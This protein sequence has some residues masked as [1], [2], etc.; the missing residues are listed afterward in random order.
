MGYSV[1]I[2]C[3]KA[4]RNDHIG[5]IGISISSNVYFFHMLESFIL[6]QSLNHVLDSWRAHLSYCGEEEQHRLLRSVFLFLSSFLSSQL[7]HIDP[8]LMMI[9][10]WISTF[11]FWMTFRQAVA[12]CDHASWGL[13]LPQLK[14]IY[15]RCALQLHSL[16]F[17]KRKCSLPWIHL[18]SSV[19][20][21]FS[22][23]TDDPL[24]QCFTPIW[25]N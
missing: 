8:T 18:S 16:L 23:W 19:L 25:S 5:I 4:L 3:M 10:Q 11:L 1:I 9:R 13:V 6:L 14:Q 2:G 17:S 15:S 22:E 24:P 12:S 20:F 21:C 7:L